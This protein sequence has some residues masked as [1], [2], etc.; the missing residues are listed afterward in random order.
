[1]LPAGA[2]DRFEDV[3]G[4]LGCLD[5][6]EDL[7]LYAYDGGVDT[8]L[9]DLVLFP[10]SVEEVA[11]IAAIAHE[12]KIPLVAR[13]AATGLSGG[14]IPCQGGVAVAFARMN[15]ILEIDLENECAIVEPGAVNLHITGAVEDRGYFFAPDPSSRRAC[16]V[17]GNVAENAG[18]VHAPA[19]GVTTNHVLGLEFVLPGGAIVQTG[20]KEPDLPGYDLTGLLTGSEG[21]MGL[22]TKIIV[23]LTRKPEAVKTAMAIYDSVEA[24]ACAAAELAGQAIAP[25]AL[26][27]FDGLILRAI[28]EATHVGYPMEASAGLLVEL[29][30][31]REQV[32]VG[33]ERIREACLNSGPRKFRVARTPKERDPLWKGRY[34][35]LGTMGRLSPAYCVPDG[36]VPRSEIPGALDFIREVSER[37][38]LSIGRI[39]HAADGAIEPVI[40]F[41]PRRPGD[42]EKAR[43]AA[44]EILRYCIRV[45]GSI[46]GGHG[47]G[48]EKVNA[49]SQLFS[50][51][52]L[53]MM[54]SLQLAFDPGGI[55][56]PGKVLPAAE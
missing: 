33:V 21:T 22:V 34:D 35:A 52:S 6:P 48:M 2:R 10:G 12:L 9:P 15:K 17:G 47:V 31:E 7:R 25:A 30:G 50:Q 16:T 20:G 8:H 4:P 18:G 44:D 19:Y 26:E 5:S 29:A 32:K 46:T 39:V 56:N 55:L 54:R 45:G 36:V 49:M 1:M 51:E 37:H 53:A 11:A 40:L 27:M 13:G 38:G 14:S 23:R 43:A 3:V 24:A 41:D 42:P 28:E